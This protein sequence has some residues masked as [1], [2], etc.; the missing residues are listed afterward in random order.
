VD[1]NVDRDADAGDHLFASS[2]QPRR[3]NA[4]V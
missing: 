4:P 3:A 2:P 1:G